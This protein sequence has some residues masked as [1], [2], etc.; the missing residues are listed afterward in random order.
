LGLGCD[1]PAYSI[2]RS[3]STQNWGRLTVSKKEKNNKKELAAKSKEK[4]QNERLPNE[5]C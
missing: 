1:S 3:T 4:Q 5:Q 2:V